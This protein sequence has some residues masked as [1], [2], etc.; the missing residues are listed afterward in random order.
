MHALIILDK[1]YT[2]MSI[3][4]GNDLSANW[5]T[6]TSNRTWEVTQQTKALSAK[7]KILKDSLGQ[8]QRMGESQIISQRG[9][10]L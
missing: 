7:H 6:N 3:Y 5:K 1:F 10:R 2:G 8:A 4:R 9:K